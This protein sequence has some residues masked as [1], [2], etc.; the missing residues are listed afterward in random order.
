MNA[1]QT[2]WPIKP[3]PYGIVAE[4]NSSTP[5]IILSPDGPNNIQSNAFVLQRLGVAGL[6]MFEDVM[7]H[8]RFP[9]SD[10]RRQCL[11]DDRLWTRELQR[12][13]GFSTRRTFIALVRD[14]RAGG[15][16]CW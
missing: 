16:G 2:S 3:V 6:D 15:G 13:R 1:N 5:C 4:F 10:E 9:I 11:R 14:A 8:Q 12:G 7:Q